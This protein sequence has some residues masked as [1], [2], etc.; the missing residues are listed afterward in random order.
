M[1]ATD[2]LLPKK[3]VTLIDDDGNSVKLDASVDEQHTGESDVTDFP[4]EE[5]ANTSDNSRPK[6]R[7]FTI[8]GFVTSAPL[9]GLD[10]YVTAPGLKELRGKRVWDRLDRWRRSGARLVVR[11]SFYTYIDVVL[12]SIGVPRNVRNSDGAELLL[13]FKQVFTSSS[14]TVAKPVRTQKAQSTS[15]GKKVN[16]A[17]PA[18]VA[19]AG[20]TTLLAISNGIGGALD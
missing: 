16:K 18:P 20:E 8:H 13:S 17:P 15:L 9:N 1:P 2:L 19:E 5:G 10:A 6:P 7:T 14:K 11:T 3:Q 12:T 4:V